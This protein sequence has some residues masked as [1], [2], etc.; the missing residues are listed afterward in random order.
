MRPSDITTSTDGSVPTTF[1]FP[2]PV[3]LD[4]N[5]AFCVVLLSDSDEYTVFCGEMGQKAINQQTLPS[6]QGKIYSQ[7]FAM[8]SLFKSQ[9]G[10][11]WTPA[12]FEDM[13][14]KL[15]RA[16]YTSQRGLITF[17]NPP[18]EPNNSQVPRLNFNPIKGLPKKAKIG[19]TTTTNAGLIGTVFTQGRKIGESNQTHRYAFVDDKGGPVDGTVGILTGG[20]GY[21]T[22]TNPVSTYNITGDGSG[23][24]LNVT[25]SAGLSAIT[26]ATVVNDGNGYKVG[27]IVGLTTADTGNAGSGVRLGISSIAGVDTL[28][29]TNVQAQEFEVTSN[30]LTYTHSSGQ[31]IDSGLDIWQYDETGGQ[32]TGEYF[33]VDHRNH[34][35]YGTGNKVLISDAASDVLPTEL[36]VDIASNETSISVASTSQFTEF[37]GAVV[38]AANTGY[39]FLNSEIIS[40]TSVGISS[41]GGVTRGTKGTNALNHLQGDAITKYEL[42]GV[43]LGKINTEHSV[44]TSLV[45]ID[46]YYI[47]INRG[48]SRGSDDNTNNIPQLSFAEEASGG[49]NSVYAS[50]NIQYDAIRTNIDATTFGPTDFV[51]LTLRSVTGTSV[52][53]NEASFVDVGFENIELNRDNQ[54]ASTRIIASRVNEQNQLG[55]LDRNKSHTITVEFDN[56]GDDFNSPT[57]SLEGAASLLYENRLNAPVTN[58]L[59][60]ARVKQRFNDPHSAYYMSNPIYIKN[61]ATSIRVIFEAR[62]PPTTDFRVLHSTLRADSSEVT[63]GFELFPGYANLLDIDG[64][65]IGDQ[66][67]DPNNNSGLPDQFIPPDATTYR[68]YQYTV[69]NLPSFTGFQIKIVFTGTDQ[70]KHPVIKNLRAIAVA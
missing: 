43:S 63:P 24:T 10:S 1:T 12:Q 58:Y 38:S 7:Q 60:D 16:K 59:T 4:P 47:K 17:F 8:G 9:N 36:S 61:P 27:D 22:P 52:D 26:A 56:G 14:F 39:A 64:D 21:G 62:R 34:G 11:T 55:S 53:G 69:D 19:I 3:Y 41:L 23:L 48:S 29:L 66:I 54:L 5:E 13:T 31:V 68:E 42:N 65:G 20:K 25:V 35:M 15:Y 70:S 67:I 18:I 44:E 6:A 45:G 40:Y 46:E 28:Y 33:K 32:Y 49:G 30:D 50:K 2:S 51:S 37:E 57:I